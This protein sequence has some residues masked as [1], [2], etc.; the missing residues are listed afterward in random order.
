MG[1]PGCLQSLHVESI[2]MQSEPG[3]LKHLINQRK[4]NQLE[5]P[6]VA[7]SEFG[8]AGKYYELD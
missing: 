8:L 4:R 3:E 7:A 5:I 2:G 6:I 1:K